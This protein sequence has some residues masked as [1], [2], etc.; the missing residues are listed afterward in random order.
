MSKIYYVENL[1]W[2]GVVEPIYFIEDE[3][4]VCYTYTDNGDDF[5]FEQTWENLEHFKECWKDFQKHAI[6]VRVV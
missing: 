1:K 5:Y 3:F 4:G 2:D 6:C